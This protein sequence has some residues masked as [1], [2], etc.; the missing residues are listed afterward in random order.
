MKSNAAR[1]SPDFR[2]AI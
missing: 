1:T 2:P